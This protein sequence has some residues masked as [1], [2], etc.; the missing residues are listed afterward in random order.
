[1]KTD[2]LKRRR[3]EP[4]ERVEAH[5][6]LNGGNW[7]TRGF[8]GGGFLEPSVERHGAA[9]RGDGGAPTHGA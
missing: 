1:M 6:T 9:A 5:R 3:P 2:E 8:Q 7:R 4:V